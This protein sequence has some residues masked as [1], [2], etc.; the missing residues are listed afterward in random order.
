MK[1]KKKAIIDTY[2]SFYPVLLVVANKYATAKDINKEFCWYD[3]VD[4]SESD[5]NGCGGCMLKVIRKSDRSRCVLVKINDDDSVSKNKR[6]NDLFVAVHEAAHVALTTYS[7]TE[8]RICC[9]DCKQEPFCYY[10]EWVFK[11][12]YKT[13]TKK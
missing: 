2:E 1:N 10:I 4:L 5:L 9:D 6:E 12:I 7:L 13:L 11:C 8:D 3:G